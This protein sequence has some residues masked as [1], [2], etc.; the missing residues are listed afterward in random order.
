MSKI[1]IYLLT[2]IKFLEHVV[3]Y[4][5]I[6][7]TGKNIAKKSDEPVKKEYQKLQV[8]KLPIIEVTQK[9]DYTKLLEE[10][11]NTHGKHLRPVKPQKN[12]KAIVPESVTCPCCGA[13]SKY[14]YDN[15]G[16][17]GQ[18][19]CKVCSST[20]NKK[21]RYLKEAIF[22]CPYCGKVLEKI[23]ERKDFNVFKC[24]ND[25]CSFYTKNLKS[26]SKDDK[27]RFKSNPNDFKVR[28][29]YRQFNFNFKPLSKSNP[30]IPK[31][32]LAKLY[33]PIHTVCLALTY[34]VN[35]NMSSRATASIMRD[36]H[37]VDI[38]HQTVLNY[39]DSVAKI[40]KPFIDNY[41]YDVSDSICGDE[42]YI[43]VNGKW[44]YIFFFIDTIKKT[45][46]SY[47]VSQ[48]RDTLSAIKAIDDV[49]TKLKTIPDN[50]NLVTD[51]NPIYLLAQHFFAE[52]G[53][54]FDV[55]QVIGLTNKDAVS[56]KYRVLKQII[57]RL[58][59]TFK[60]NY[61]H[62]RGFNSDD[63]SVSF[64]TLF[65]IY[66]NFLRPHSALGYSVPVPIPELEKLPH[67][68]AK[69]GKLIEL[70]QDYILKHQAA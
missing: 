29:I 47:R 60:G 55:T 13:P 58:N 10:Y 59:G 7:L 53:I 54:N 43:R 35:Y 5:F 30:V 1:N 22:K 9:Y 31:V 70:S 24:K 27:L 51:G 45:L 41:D 66:Y 36:V 17:R 23:K 40:I 16:G 48:N 11:F 19:R 32:S 65:T 34:H 8:D 28:Y 20:F 52:N 68:P 42:T 39:A 33:A 2:Y 67:M 4:L 25:T 50:L 63:G 37:G 15:T 57:E 14:I 44:H 56:A 6:A 38:S 69:W 3:M 62:T 49:I 21:N 64:V 26:M 61:R 46:L 18:Y 12:S